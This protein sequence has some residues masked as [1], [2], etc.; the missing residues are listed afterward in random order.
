MKVFQNIDGGTIQSCRE[1][2]IAPATKIEVGQVVDLTTGLVTAHA[3]AGTGAILGVAA[4]YHSGEADALNPRANG[5][6]I[7]VYDAP[8]QVFVCK[9][10]E[11]VALA[12]GSATTLKATVAGAADVY[13]G[14][15]LKLVSKAEGSTNTDAIGTVYRIEDFATDAGTGT[16]TKAQGGVPSEGDVYALFMPVGFEGGNLDA[17]G[18][19]IVVTATAALPLRVV[20][21]LEASGEIMVTPVKHLLGYKG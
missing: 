12:G 16:F 7:L 21:R 2:D 15:Y 8:G 4:E 11:M 14:G 13:N 10:P 1:Y 5:T 18:C 19:K 3:A 20:G 6:K 9:A 17:K